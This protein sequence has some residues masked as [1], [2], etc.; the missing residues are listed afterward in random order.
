MA[1][2]LET[3]PIF[4]DADATTTVPDGPIGGQTRVTLRN[5]HLQYI[6]T[7]YSL[8]LITFY[9]FYQFSRKKKIFR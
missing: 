8:S 5:E 1:T 7:W 9:M 6:F 3:A 4:I 2:Q